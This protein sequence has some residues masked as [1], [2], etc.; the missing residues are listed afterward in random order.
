MRKN[1]LRDELRRYDILCRNVIAIRGILARLVKG[2]VE[3]CRAYSVGEI[4]AMIGEPELGT[5]PLGPG[6]RTRIREEES[7]DKVPGEG[8]VYFDIVFRLHLPGGTIALVV[9]VE[10]QDSGT[11]ALNVRRGIFYLCRLVSRQKGRDFQG[12]DYGG[13]LKVYSIWIVTS[14]R[15]R[16]ASVQVFRMERSEYGSR[17]RIPRE[18]YDKLALVVVCLGETDGVSLEKDMKEAV[19]LLKAALAKDLAFEEK[20]RILQERY[21]IRLS[22]DEAEEVRKMGGM[23][24]AVYRS[25]VLQGRQEGRQEGR[26][27]AGIQTWTQSVENVMRCYG[28]SLDEAMRNL[29]VPSQYQKA[30]RQAVGGQA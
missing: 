3:E 7:A 1:F 29:N 9:N 16:E 26:E 18:A 13:L 14:P 22:P 27:E 6:L 15:R 24:E 2:M 20:D 25:G 28:S 30:V 8:A 4:E 5:A 11:F 17:V 12:D 23:G 21:G 10:V 19:E